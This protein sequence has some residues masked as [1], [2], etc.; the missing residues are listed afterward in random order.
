MRDDADINNNSEMDSHTADRLSISVRGKNALVMRKRWK[1]RGPRH[2]N[3]IYNVT[4]MH[5][6]R[7]SGFVCIDRN[8]DLVQPS[9]DGTLFG[10]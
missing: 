5:T 2:N 10:P 8:D 3:L 9:E 4:E 6:T 7:L 1:H